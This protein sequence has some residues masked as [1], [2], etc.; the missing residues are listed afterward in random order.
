MDDPVP[1]LAAAFPE[2]HEHVET[3]ISHVFLSPGEVFKVKK[4]VDFGFLDFRTLDARRR[5]CEA[6]VRLG[7]RLSPDVYL[8]VVPIVRDARGVVRRAAPDSVG[9]VVDVAVHMRRLPDAHRADIRL[10]EGR[11]DANA[12]ETIATRLVAF[13]ATA[14]KTPVYGD[15]R[16]V[17]RNVDENFEQT[18]SALVQILGPRE[19]EALRRFQYGRLAHLEPVLRRRAWCGRAIDGHGDLRLEH[20]YVDDAGTVRIIDCVEFNERLRCGDVAAD[21][22][23]LSMDLAYHGRSD[24]AERLVARVAEGLHDFGL[25][26]VV[27][28]FES[29]RA[30]VRAKI[31]TF[32][33]DAPGVTAARREAA[34]RRARRYAR[35]AEAAGRPPLVEPFV[36]AITGGI[37][38][39][40]STLARAVADR[41]AA[42]LVGTDATRKFM[43]GVSPTQSLAADPHT[44]AYDPMV[45]DAVYDEVLRRA[46]RVLASGRPVVLDGTFGA[47][48]HRARILRLAARHGV[49]VVVVVGRLDRAERLAR[50]A[51]RARGPSESDG[52]AEILDALDAA[53]EAPDDLPDT[54]RLDLDLS[55]PL[56]ENITVLDRTLRVSS[57]P[58][59]LP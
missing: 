31:E 18:R 12:L 33:R 47:R 42:P 50:L 41:Y 58:P 4:P 20:V 13:F 8:G 35:L 26:Q 37:G 39:G 17:R 38:V 30:H 40:K 15:P 22:A 56:E 21:L 44:G 1:P 14:R 32:V 45:T 43:L 28:F 6:E 7:R 34:G 57:L 55:R 29:Y 23:F 54:V 10:R 48:T 49:R 3:H 5:A 24:L 46:D 16:F 9:D 59:S 19:A 51:R 11:L 52:R 25:Y 2:A 36:L 53:V 27:D